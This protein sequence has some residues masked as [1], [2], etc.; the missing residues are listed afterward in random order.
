MKDG[1]KA[2]KTV[3]SHLLGDVPSDRGLMY[4]IRHIARVTPGVRGSGA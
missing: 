2:K 3:V 1:S 4:G